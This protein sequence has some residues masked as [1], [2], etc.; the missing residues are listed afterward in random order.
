MGMLGTVIGMID[1]FTSMG[2]TGADVKTISDSISKALITT[3]VGLGV[4]I[5]GSITIISKSKE[6]GEWCKLTALCKKPN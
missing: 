6:D 3:L 1:C 5:F 4:A 2:M